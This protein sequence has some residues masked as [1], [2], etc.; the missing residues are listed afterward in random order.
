MPT[1]AYTPDYAVP[2]GASLKE[3]LES[4]EMPQ[5]EFAVRMG[6]TEKTISQIIN[7]TAPISYETASKLEMVLGVPA[8]FWNA[9][10][11]QYRDAL[12][13]E[14]EAERFQE[15]KE[16]LRHLP[17]AELVKR[18]F[19]SATEDVALKVRQ[20]LAFFGVT[21]IEAWK[22]I[23]LHPQVQFRGAKAH[24]RHPGYVA[25]WQR[26]G[27]I[28]AEQIKCKPYDA[29]TFRKALGEI[30]KLT[31]LPASVWKPNLQALCAEAGVAVVLIREIHT[32]RVSGIT[33][34]VSK[35][36]ALIILSLK[37]KTDDQVWFSFFHEAGHILKHAK[38]TIFYEDGIRKDDPLEMEAN[39]FAQDILIPPEHAMTLPLLRSRA[40]IRDFAAS[41]GISPGIVVGQMQHF[42]LIGPSAYWDLKIRYQWTNHEEQK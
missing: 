38:K 26:M 5:A 35:D 16:W 8:H 28:A 7:G 19:I 2:S 17:V 33:K 10:E 30:R 11:A 6:M 41:I 42:N 9:R 15:E 34:W 25:A 14:K 31:S 32:A 1:F 24:E 27:E 3:I 29:A 37:Y 39:K 18:N 36:K 4:K 40:A 21:S 22:E 20:A 23:W 13:R 12:L